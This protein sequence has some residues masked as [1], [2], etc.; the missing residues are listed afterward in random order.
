MWGREEG[1]RK[2]R[3]EGELS[4][5]PKA[6]KAIPE[7]DDLGDLGAGQRMKGWESSGVTELGTRGQS[8]LAG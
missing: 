2:P 6:G 3:L 5:A 7:A 1:K 4:S 8:R